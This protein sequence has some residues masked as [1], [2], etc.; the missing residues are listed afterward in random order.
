MPKNILGID[1][2]DWMLVYFFDQTHNIDF[3]EELPIYGYLIDYFFH[4]S[5]WFQ[6][7]DIFMQ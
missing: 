7:H 6:N 5:K 3:S 2:E 1:D 4:A